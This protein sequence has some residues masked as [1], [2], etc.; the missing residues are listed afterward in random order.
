MSKSI[1]RDQ[2]NAINA[3]MSNGFR[4]DVRHYLLWSQ[5]QA[6]K[7]IQIDD[8]TTLTATLTWMDSYERKATTC[9]QTINVPNGLHHIALHLAVWHHRDGGQVA[10]SHG[11][12][13]WIDVGPAVKRCNFSDIQKITANYDDASILALY[14]AKQHAPGILYA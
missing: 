5:K 10:T 11:L 2:I 4:L 12:G 14:D 9:G 3:K 13:Q 7:P 6:V 1:T 8:N